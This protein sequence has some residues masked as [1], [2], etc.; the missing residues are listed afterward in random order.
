MPDVPKS[1]LV[2]RY[3]KIILVGDPITSEPLY[4]LY[5]KNIRMQMEEMSK[6]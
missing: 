4:K 2:D 1:F 3:G 5:R 6:Q